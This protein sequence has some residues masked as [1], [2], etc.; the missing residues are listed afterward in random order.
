MLPLAL[1]AL[2]YVPYKAVAIRSSTLPEDIHAYPKFKISFLHGR[3]VLNATAQQWLRDGI[4][5]EREFLDLQDSPATLHSIYKEIGSRQDDDLAPAA[6]RPSA[7]SAP[8]LQHMRL[9]P[10]E[11]LCLLLPPPDIP[12]SPDDTLQ[13]AQP[14]RTWELLQP[15]EGTCLYVREI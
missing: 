13:T 3:P 11:Y 9:G 14:T 5:G 8:T 12:A 2:L 15:L 6:A 10:Q 1:I 7:P 4:T